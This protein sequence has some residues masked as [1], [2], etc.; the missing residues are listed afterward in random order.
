MDIKAVLKDKALWAMV[1]GLIVSIIVV[2]FNLVHSMSDGTISVDE[3]KTI[4]SPLSGGGADT[5]VLF[6]SALVRKFWVGE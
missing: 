6:L 3:Y 4:L 5:T 2:I 1:I